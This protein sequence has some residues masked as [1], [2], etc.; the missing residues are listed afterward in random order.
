MEE[1]KK[2]KAIEIKHG[3]SCGIE[4]LVPRELPF[5]IYL[6]EEKLVALLATP[7]ELKELAV[8]YLYSEGI[9]KELA[10]LKEVLVDEE[11]R[12]I[13]ITTT[14]KIHLDKIIDRRFI[15]SGS[16]K[17]SSFFSVSDIKDIKKSDSKK[18]VSSSDVSLL[19]EAMYEKSE[20]HKKAGGVHASAISDGK[21]IVTISEDI[22]RNNTIDKV[23][24][25]CFLKGIKADDKILLSTGRTS[26]EMLLKAASTGI[27]I[28]VSRTAATDLAI[29]A[30]RELEITLV[31]YIRADAMRVYANEWRIT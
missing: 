10:D 13:S 28:V 5:T 21:K 29:Q 11:K 25:Y 12:T 2:I 7:K 1:I 4:A 30:A 15:T 24:G 20:L 17:G 6:N 23:L 8:G 14:K 26:S 16:G 18:T 19:M 9:L 27:P 3:E 22:G 31:S